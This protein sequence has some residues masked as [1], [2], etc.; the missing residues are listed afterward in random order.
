METHDMSVLGLSPT[1]EEV[2][3]HFLRNPRTSPHDLH[4]LLRSDRSS[5]GRIVARLRELLLLQGEADDLWATDPDI[6][7]P[8]LVEERLEDLHRELRHLAHTRP[9]LESLHRDR[10]APAGGQQASTTGIERLED[11]RL[12]RGRIDDLAFFAREEVLS[13]EPYDAL[14]KENIEHARP[15]DLRCLRRGVRIRNLVRAATLRDPATLAYLRELHAHGAEIR[16]APEFSE[17]MLIYDRHTAL[18]PIDPGDTAKGALLARENGL[19]GNIITLFGRLWDA[20]EDFTALVDAGDAATPELSETQRQVLICMCEVPKDEAGAR[21]VGVSLRTYRR[22]IADL[23]HLLDADN[24]AQ[25]A[26][27]ARERG[28]I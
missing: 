24:R 17:L 8:R 16:V 4:V 15:L 9:L 25:A 23:M 13:A 10:P 1:E 3:R 14:S 20:A 26:L 18:V 27:L 2:Y 19:V 21:K 12:V 28:W 7:V 5:A 11:L 6:A 22:H